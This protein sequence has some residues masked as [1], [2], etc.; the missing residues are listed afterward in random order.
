MLKDAATTRRAVPHRRQPARGHAPDGVSA[1][2]APARR[3]GCVQSGRRRCSRTPPTFATTSASASCAWTGSSRCTARSSRSP[4]WPKRNSTWCCSSPV[5]GAASAPQ[6]PA[7]RLRAAMTSASTTVRTAPRRTPS[8]RTFTARAGERSLSRPTSPSKRTSSALFAAVDQQ[9][10]R[11][12]A[13]VN[14][15][16]ILERQGRVDSVDAARLSRI[17]AT[18][19][20]GAFICAREAVKRMST[21][22]GG[23]GGAIVNVS[24]RAAVLGAPGEYVDYAASKGALDT[25]T[26]GLAKEVAG[27]GIRVNGVR[28]GHHLHRHSRQ[29]RRARPRRSPW[30]D[31]ADGA[32]RQRRR[33]RPRDP[34]AAVGRSV[35]HDG[36]F[37]RRCRADVTAELRRLLKSQLGPRGN[38]QTLTQHERFAEVRRAKRIV[39]RRHSRVGRPRARMTGSSIPSSVS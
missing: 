20:T 25:L 14:N 19:V 26:V 2:G 8:S 22:Y 4:N 24:S 1:Q 10:G 34:L 27:E 17:F 15:A 16:G 31:L 30:P 23:A 7:W 38:A 5:A 37:R 36:Q 35:L 29:R 28:A 3:S 39:G 13:L 11:L 12:T 21:K 18:N 32:R 6:P 33:S 9:L